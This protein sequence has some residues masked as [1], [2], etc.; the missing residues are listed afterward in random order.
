MQREDRVTTQA[1]INLIVPLIL[2]ALIANFIPYFMYITP[3][4]ETSI[5]MLFFLTKSP[6][7]LD[8]IDNSMFYSSIIVKYIYNLLELILLYYYYKNLNKMN[9]S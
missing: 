7:Q 2:F 3:M 4:D 5:C 8:S 6:F 1:T 9:L